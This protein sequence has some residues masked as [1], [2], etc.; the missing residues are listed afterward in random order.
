MEQKT[1]RPFQRLPSY[2]EYVLHYSHLGGKNNANGL[3]RTTFIICLSLC[4]IYLST[5]S[6]VCILSFGPSIYI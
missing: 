3:H 6:F 5:Y 1:G 4:L 2:I